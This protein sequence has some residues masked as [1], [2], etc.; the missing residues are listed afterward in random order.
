MMPL[1]PVVLLLFV[2]AASAHDNGQFTNSPLKGWFNQLA[3]GKGLCCSFA[4]GRTVKGPD[5][6]T[7]AVA[8]ADG[9]SAIVYWVM[10]DGQKIDVPP[11]AVVTEP[12]RYGDAVV[13]PYK[14]YEGKTRIRCF[15]PGPGA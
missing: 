11:E 7:E 5:W 6:G 4:D 1:W 15:L 9:K 12:N 3:S 2:T 13:W 10:V 8:G 14:N